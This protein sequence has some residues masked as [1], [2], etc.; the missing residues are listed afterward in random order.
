MGNRSRFF[1][2]NL[3]HM[4]ATETTSLTERRHDLDWLRVIAIII[5]LFFHTGMWFNNWGWHVKNNELTT[6]FQYWMIWSHNFR[7]QLLLF[8]SG[9]GTFIALGSRTSSQFR[10]D[11]YKR[12]LVPL[13]F[14][15]L[16]IVPPQIYYER[17][18]QYTSYWDFYKT[19]FQFKP[20]PEGGSLSW[21]HLWFILYLLVYSL[22]A[23]PFL[24]YL[25]SP[26]S[27]NFRQKSN[28][29][30]SSP[31][32]MLF[33]PSILILISQIILR[34]YFPEETHNLFKDWA[35]FIY[36]FAFF[37][38]GSICYSIPEL[39]QAIGNNRTHFLIALIFA[40]IPFYA[41]YFHF[42][43]LITLPA[44]IDTIETIFDVSAIFVS[45]FTVITIIGFGQHYLNKPS[46]WLAP[47]N[48]GLYPFYILHQSVIIAIGYYVCQW[49]WSISAKY[50]MICFLTAASCTAFYIWI[51]RPFNAMRFLFGLKTKK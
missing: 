1:A 16:V 42:R 34:P 33:I 51:I 43:E 40:L 8:I 22:L 24:K 50:W 32:A 12:L 45:W 41:C 19:V 28:K 3:K 5:L 7:M 14:G 11:R 49:N 2:Q 48:E 47:I 30:L 15:M 31:A 23:L 29:M 9:A 17:I 37:L 18:S 38:M 4:I 13:I 46:R 21:H 39:W 44:H 25:R 26:N 6:S 10:K 20:Y 27:E 36:Y 35:Y